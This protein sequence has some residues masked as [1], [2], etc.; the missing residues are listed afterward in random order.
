MRS[1]FWSSTGPVPQGDRTCEQING[2]C[3]PREPLLI[4]PDLTQQDG[5]AGLRRGRRS[6]NSAMVNQFAL[7]GVA[8]V[9]TSS[10]WV[11]HEPE[12]MSV[13][14]RLLARPPC[15]PIGQPSTMWNLVI[16]ASV[17]CTNPGPV[18]TKASH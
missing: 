7:A 1:R 2:P 3:S 16:F 8:C 6:R 15:R 13:V 18:D 10:V 14:S 9:L 4:S 17:F 5:S 11:H 12:V